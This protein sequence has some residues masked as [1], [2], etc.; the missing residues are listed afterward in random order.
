MYLNVNS[1]RI[2]AGS[3]QEHIVSSQTSQQKRILIVAAVA[4]S[5]LAA[6][7]L[8]CKCCF[9]AN[10]QKPAE[11]PEVKAAEGI[12]QTEK[13]P[14]ENPKAKPVEEI[15]QTEQ[16][17]K[18]VKAADKTPEAVDAGKPLQVDVPDEV[19]EEPVVE[20]ESEPLQEQ[21]GKTKVQ[22]EEVEA[23]QAVEEV[24][25]KKE[26]EPPAQ[27]DLPE[28]E[29]DPMEQLRGE[30]QKAE[31]ELT[32]IH[33]KAALEEQRILKK[34]EEA[35]KQA[36]KKMAVPP[37][38]FCTIETETLG[39]QRKAFLL[40]CQNNSDCQALVEKLTWGT[41]IKD[42]CI[43]EKTGVGLVSGGGLPLTEGGTQVVLKLKTEKNTDDVFDLIKRNL[44]AFLKQPPQTAVK[45]ITLMQ[46][47]RQT[48]DDFVAARDLALSK[49]T[50][51]FE[52]AKI[53]RKSDDEEDRVLVTC[54]SNEDL[55]T[56]NEQLMHN[57]DIKDFCIF[58][59]VEGQSIHTGAVQLIIRVSRQRQNLMWSL[60]KK[61][62]YK[63]DNDI[64]ILLSGLD[65]TPKNPVR[66]DYPISNS[67]ESHYNDIYKSIHDKRVEELR[68]A[69][70]NKP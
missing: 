51:S 30:V 5:C 70:K 67:A 55:R 27:T 41:S 31:D 63:S 35:R 43:F 69:G 60:N 33:Q 29:I 61:Y 9:K 57:T 19:Q 6:I 68:N 7:F 20:E 66:K 40:I 32:A 45:E 23:D 28:T 4:L 56:L 37:F 14:G 62:I 18:E 49:K 59:C 38:E 48:S 17:T 1:L 44:L 15:K 11:D 8:V 12:K 39:D 3:I 25:E 54:Q 65:G 21:D 2:N 47:T 50:P 34:A 64:H 42:L 26:P 46:L 53:N 10:V 16:G 36:A 24:V 22:S 52:Y 58:D 13:K